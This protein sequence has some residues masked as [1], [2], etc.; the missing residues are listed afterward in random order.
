MVRLDAIK[1]GCPHH[2]SS[3][4]RTNQLFI[5]VPVKYRFKRRSSRVGACDVVEN[6]IL[7][8]F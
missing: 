2:E 1:A 4:K 3:F 5:L 7:N 8:D 6:D